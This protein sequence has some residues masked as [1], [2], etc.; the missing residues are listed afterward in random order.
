MSTGTHYYV[1]PAHYSSHGL[2]SLASLPARPLPFS[3]GIST[4]F[5]SA[6]ARINTPSISP[7]VSTVCRSPSICS[8][9][10]YWFLASFVFVRS[11]S[12]AG[13]ADGIPGTVGTGGV[14]LLGSPGHMRAGF[15]DAPLRTVFG[16]GRSG[17]ASSATGVMV[18]SCV[19]RSSEPRGVCCNDGWREIRYEETHSLCLERDHCVVDYGKV[20]S[21]DKGGER[22][23]QQAEEEERDGEDLAQRG[24][25]HHVAVPRRAHRHER[26]PCCLGDRVE[27]RHVAVGVDERAERRVPCP[28]LRKVYERREEHEHEKDEIRDGHQRVLGPPHSHVHDLDGQQHLALV[29]ERAEDAEEA[30]RAQDA[31][32]EQD[33][34]VLLPR[35]LNVVRQDREQVRDGEEARRPLVVLAP[36]VGVCECTREVFHRKEHDDGRV[37]R[38][39]HA[40]RRRVR[41]ERR[42]RRKRREDHAEEYRRR[43]GDMHEERLAPRTRLFHEEVQLALPRAAHGRGHGEMV[44]A[45]IQP[46]HM[47]KVGQVDLFAVRAQLVQVLL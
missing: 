21:E 7:C 42:Q 10:T 46:Q 37:K 18:P 41:V 20:A 29:P 38:E 27:E 5:F 13:L 47:P 8:N 25:R 26:V 4:P 1:Y 17:P 19:S 45:D 36:R 30:E 24:F 6:N 44:F 43:H 11:L 23:E 28:A 3:N 40:H 33:R 35:Q 34:R 9:S 22:D 15:G 12:R 31:E 14:S 39:E 2:W 16:A 32:A